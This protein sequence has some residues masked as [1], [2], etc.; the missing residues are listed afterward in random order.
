MQKTWKK[1]RP[2]NNSKLFS[3]VHFLLSG[4]IG[5][6]YVWMRAGSVRMLQEYVKV[7]IPINKYLVLYDASFLQ[8]LQLSKRELFIVKS[9]DSLWLFGRDS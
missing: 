1:K 9:K 8:I 2:L 7:P 6:F 5:V 4:V 3:F